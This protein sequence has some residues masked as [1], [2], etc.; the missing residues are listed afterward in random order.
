[1]DDTNINRKFNKTQKEQIQALVSESSDVLT[2]LP[3]KTTIIK[4]E[5][6]LVSD[7]SVR[8]KPYSVPHALKDI[9]KSEI[10]NMLRM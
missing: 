3:A 9:G 1:M 8:S 6:N 7:N 5:I 10:E 2:D 4:H